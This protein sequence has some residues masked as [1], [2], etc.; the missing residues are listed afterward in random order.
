[1]GDLFHHLQDIADRLALTDYIVEV[2]F[3]QPISAGST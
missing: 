2:K 3:H 1:M